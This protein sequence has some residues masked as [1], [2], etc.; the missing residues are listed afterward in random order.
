MQDSNG[1][2]EHWPQIKQLFRD[3][4]KSSLHFS[5]ATVD[6]RGAPHISPIGSLLLGEPGQGI[7]FEEFSQA[8]R[9]HIQH[10]PN[11]CVLAVNSDKWFW[12]K[13]L[14]HGRFGAAPALRLYG[15]AGAARP[16]NAQE[17]DLWQRR[18]QLLR[19]SQ[20]HKN[21]WANMRQVRELHFDR[22]QAVNL[23]RM[24]AKL[25]PTPPRSET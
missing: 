14:I 1:L 18:V 4:F 19:F 15:R 6:E 25:W 5:I 9:R 12:I 23:G 16:A 17:I 22:M 3:S 7:Y 21:L 11:I 10:N 20:G 8:L 2:Y 13:S 24:T